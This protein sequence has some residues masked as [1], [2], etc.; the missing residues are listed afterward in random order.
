MK[1]LWFQLLIGSQLSI[2]KLINTFKG[3]F[4]WSSEMRR[5]RKEHQW[6]K[7]SV[8]PTLTLRDKS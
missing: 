6:R 2:K 8:G 4:W 1:L 5:D 3:N 7:N